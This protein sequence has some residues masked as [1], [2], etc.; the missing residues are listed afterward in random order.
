MNALFDVERFM[1]HGHCF[2]W[3]PGILWSSV[4][5]D[6]LIAAAYMVIPF[7]LVFRIMRKRDLPF[8]WMFFCFGVFIV[9]CGTTHIVDI[10]VVWIP[11]YG[12]AAVIK[13]INTAW[14]AYWQCSVSEPGRTSAGIGGIKPPF[15]SHR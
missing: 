9:A 2:Q 15:I 1:P 5:S 8:N 7:T 3:D 11:F 14:A 6:A 4:T 13:A 12:L 10:I